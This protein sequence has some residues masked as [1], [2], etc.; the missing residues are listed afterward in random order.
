MSAPPLVSILVPAYNRAE[1]V[2]PCVESAL[3]QSVDDIEVVIVDNASTDGTWEVCQ[4][5]AA[6][7]SR[8]RVFR[9]ATNIGPVR[10]WARCISEARGTYG[11]LLFSDDTIAPAFLAKTIPWLED[12]QVGFVFT[13]ARVGVSHSEARLELMWPEGTGRY[14]S[15]RFI[16]GAL[17][18]YPWNPASPG[19]ALFRLDDLRRN[20]L[21]EL[22][23]PVRHD[24]SAHGAGSDL[25]LFL[26]TA[27]SHPA[28]ATV[29]EPLVFFRA[30]AGSLTAGGS[31]GDVALSYALATF[32]FGRTCVGSPLAD[33]ALARHWLVEGR[34]SGRLRT[35]MAA[36]RRYGG[37]IS[38]FRLTVEGLAV[39]VSKVGQVLRDHVSPRS[40]P[41][42]QA[43]AGDPV[44]PG[45]IDGGRRGPGE[46]R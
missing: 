45:R 25:L 39:L 35:P 10:N 38:P 20:L 26:L 29:A 7:D 12:P 22:P 8:V 14:P 27:L 13:A 28:F 36:A 30:H 42:P 24:M 2:V 40:R 41:M 5:F 4:R 6:R 11:K 18:P 31:G 44:W 21:A 3:A 23:P 34:T 46:L 33:R 32:W 15:G 17:E 19:C 16:R 1:L 43:A 9:N 37:A